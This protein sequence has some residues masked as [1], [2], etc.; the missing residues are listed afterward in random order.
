MQ[1]TNGHHA[2]NFRQAVETQLQRVKTV[3]LQPSPTDAQPRGH[4]VGRGPGDLAP[5]SLD[6]RPHG[7]VV[8]HG[9][10]DPALRSL[11]GRPHGHV[12]GHGPDEPA[13]RSLDGRPHG[14]VV[15]HETD[16][17][18]RRTSVAKRAAVSVTTGSAASRPERSVDRKAA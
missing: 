15:G 14:H 7:H 11:D 9:P 3:A 4:V 17:S 10:G 5:R 1:D 2:D 16:D 12:V 6:G 13:P 18:A 8:G